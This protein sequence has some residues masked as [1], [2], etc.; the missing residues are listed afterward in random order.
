MSHK[1]IYIKMDNTW[2]VNIH[3]SILQITIKESTHFPIS[4]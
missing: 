4:S 1:E 3:Y 2:N